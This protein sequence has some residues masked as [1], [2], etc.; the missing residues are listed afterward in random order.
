MPWF[1]RAVCLAGFAALSCGCSHDHRQADIKACIAG[2]QRQTSRA[3]GQ[4]DEEFH[5]QVG[6]LV[7][8]CMKQA[9]Y[10]HDMS[11]EQCLDDVD[12][13][14]SCYLRRRHAALN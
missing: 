9:G 8:D 10:R 5:D 4:S 14:P 12:Y 13:N 6:E 2:A 3:P 11:S 7:A 1:V